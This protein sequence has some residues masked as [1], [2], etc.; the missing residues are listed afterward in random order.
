MSTDARSPQLQNWNNFCRYHAD[1]WYGTWSRYTPDGQLIEFFQCVRS[2]HL[3]EDGSEIHHQNHYTYA[4]GKTETKTFGPYKKPFTRALF[5]DNS[6]SWGS[7]KVESGSNFGFE[8]GFRF[9]D[10]RL[11]VAVVYD[12][13]GGQKIV[14]IPENLTTFPEK[15]TPTSAKE[16]SSDWEGTGKTMTP[17]W[18][19]SSPI[20]TS[21]NRLDNLG[22][23]Y[24][25]LHFSDG[26]SICC[27][28]KIETG[29]EFF[30]A[31]DWQVNPA[32]LLRGIRK[33][34]NSGFTSFTLET[35]SLNV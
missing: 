33:Y 15:P 32:L 4:D 21:W 16:F 12:D 28:Q 10:R 13:G 27:P 22:E 25:T 18:I 23:D 2:F 17:D 35:F 14:V 7:T 8:T 6:F 34:D 31:V 3:S 24:L 9:E 19:V 20:P 26:I 5:L 29:K 30:A 11:S 1:D